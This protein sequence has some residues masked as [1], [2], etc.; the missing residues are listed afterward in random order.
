MQSR[1]IAPHGQALVTKHNKL[2]Q[3]RYAL[4]LQEKRLIL[5]LVSAIR[6][7]DTDF[8]SYRVSVRTLAEL[9]GL[10]KNKN[11]YAQ[12]AAVTRRLMRRVI[13]IETLDE[14][15][16]LQIHWIWGGRPIRVKLHGSVL[17]AM[18]RVGLATADGSVSEERLEAEF[19]VVHLHDAVDGAFAQFVGPRE[20]I[21]RYGS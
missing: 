2:I 5:W 9:L 4:S 8:H 3:A 20:D 12:V 1:S 18:L 13:E 16:F 15:R 21:H 11:I 7:G 10:E 6:P 17:H 14:Q 19:D